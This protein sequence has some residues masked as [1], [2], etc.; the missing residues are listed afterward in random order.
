[1]CAWIVKKVIMGKVNDLLEE[2]KGDVSKVKDTLQ[3]WIARLEKILSCFKSLLTK[4]DDGK[5]DD[6]EID[7]TAAEVENLI[8][9]W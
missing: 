4:L 2:Y 6:E 1:M 8:K 3:L 7:E 5:I 9:E